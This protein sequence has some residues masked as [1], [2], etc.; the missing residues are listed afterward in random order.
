MAQENGIVIVP[1][2]VSFGGKTYD[3]LRGAENKAEILLY[4]GQVAADENGSFSV[5]M[6]IGN[7]GEYTVYY[8]VGNN[9]VKS[10]PVKYVNILGE[11]ERLQNVISD[12]QKR[13]KS[14]R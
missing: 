2:H 6:T 1:M 14:P 13:K 12:S 9:D 11:A 10:A 4:H 7:T 8:K 5:D 3:D